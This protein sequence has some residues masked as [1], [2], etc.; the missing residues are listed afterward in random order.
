M[1]C[2][3]VSNRPYR[4]WGGVHSK[5]RSADS[6]TTIQSIE[7][8]SVFS[9]PLI[10]VVTNRNCSITALSRRYYVINDSMLDN[11]I[12]RV[13]RSSRTQSLVARAQLVSL[14]TE[15]DI[16]PCRISDLLVLISCQEYS[17]GGS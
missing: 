7:S 2:Q 15:A 6:T 3:M 16:L 11:D 13:P 8:V 4:I 17:H 10:D 5:G 12:L 1:V 9:S 14:D